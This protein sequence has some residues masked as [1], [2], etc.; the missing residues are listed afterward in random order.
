MI[1]QYQSIVALRIDQNVY[2]RLKTETESKEK[3]GVR[4]PT[5]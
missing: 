1:C 4:D 3:H 2:V 5:L